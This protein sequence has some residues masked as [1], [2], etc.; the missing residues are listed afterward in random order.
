MTHLLSKPLKA[1]TIYALIILTLSI[2]VYVFVVDYIWVSEMDKNNVLILQN[3]KQKLTAKKLSNDDIEIV[4]Q[5]WGELQTG[6]SLN[7]YNG[8]SI[9]P[10]SIYEV[11][12]KNKF[13][14]DGEEE[15]FRGLKSYLE[16]NGQNYQINI[17]TNV[18]E[19]DETLL[20]ITI[21]TCFFFLILIVGFIVLNRKIAVNSWLP[22]YKTLDALKSFDLAK[23]KSIKLPMTDI[24]EFHELNQSIDQLVQKVTKS[25]QLQKSFTE[26]ASHELQTPIALLKS[27]LDLLIQE[28]RMSPQISEIIKSIEIPLARLTRINKNLLLL[29]KVESNQF[30]DEV[31]LD[32]KKHIES[33]L[34]LFEDYIISKNMDITCFFEETNLINANLFLLE[35]MLNNLL[36]NAIRHSKDGGQI[37]IKV[38]NRRLIYY[39]SGVSPLDKLH[40]FERFSPLAVDKVSSGLGLAIIKEICMKYHW[41]IDYDFKNQNHIFTIDF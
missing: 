7:R 34:I 13:E 38:D 27:K 29:A 10:D 23:D 24:D 32:I 41:E 9:T 40:L 6:I 19:L 2:P 39:N 35:T 5:L 36:S 37:V 18:E 1:F 31:P 21:I 16:I 3:T 11:T 20:A 30:G 15:R 33:S 12:R 22:F 26:N 17:E 28:K 4:N 14:S 8:S 25:Y